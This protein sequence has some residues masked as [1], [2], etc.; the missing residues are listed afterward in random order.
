MFDAL[1]HA[2]KAKSLS[3]YLDSGTNLNLD[4]ITLLPRF[5]KLSV[6]IVADVKK[7]F[8]HIGV[9]AGNHNGQNFLWFKYRL[10]AG[11][12]LPNLETWRMTRVA[13]KTTSSL[14]L[15]AATP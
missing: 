15:L 12:P 4:I 7:A 3:D 11:R 6:M 14:F 1:S 5:W 8:L 2:A 9:C 10:E 13:L